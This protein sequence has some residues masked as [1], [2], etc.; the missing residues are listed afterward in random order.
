MD[1]ALAALVIVL[2]LLLLG[3][4]E[5]RRPERAPVRERRH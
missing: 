1:L 2:S 3:R 4:Q 5:G